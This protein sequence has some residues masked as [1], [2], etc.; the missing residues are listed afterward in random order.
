MIRELGFLPRLLAAHVSVLK[1]IITAA[2][3]LNYNY[4]PEEYKVGD[5]RPMER[6]KGEEKRTHHAVRMLKGKVQLLWDTFHHSEISEVR[7]TGSHRSWNLQVWIRA[8]NI[9]GRDKNILQKISINK[10]F[11]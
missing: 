4:S 11:R 2:Q 8:G 10:T 9:R 5:R 6:G 3:K 1:N 7:M